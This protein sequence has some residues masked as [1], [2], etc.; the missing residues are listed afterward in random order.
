M[1]LEELLEVAI[2]LIFVWLVISMATMQAQEVIASLTKK[3]AKDLSEAIGTMIENEA[4]HNKIYDHPLIKNIKVPATGW[5][6]L[7]RRKIGINVPAFD[8]PP[9][10]PAGIFATVIFDV[11]TNAGTSV[12]PIK[13]KFSALRKEVGRLKAG[14]QETASALLGHIVDLGQALAGTQ[15][16]ATKIQIRTEINARL[17]QLG[18]I[19][20][21]GETPLAALTTD[22]AGVLNTGTGDITNLFSGVGT[23]LDQ[24][25]T[26]AMRTGSMALGDA[27]TSLLAGVEEYATDADKALAIGRKNVEA[28][29]DNSM[30]RLSSWYKRWAQTWAFFIGLIIALTLNI[31]SIELAKHLWREPAIRQVLAA[32]ATKFVAENPNLPKPGEDALPDVVKDLQEKFV[33]LN[34]PVGWIYETKP[35]IRDD[36]TGK[37]KMDLE[38]KLPV[39]PNPE[40]YMTYIK[41]ASQ[42]YKIM[43]SECI[44]YTN[45]PTTKGEWSLK[46]LGIFLTAI[47]TMQGAP[48]W[49]DIL[50]KLINV[51]NTGINPAEKSKTGSSDK[52]R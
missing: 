52:E 21:N 10:I 11:V 7:F 5:W 13:D 34:L 8:N 28:W 35:V 31:D 2:G 38:N 23:Y 24:I 30:D 37:I 1:Y 49:F 44:L 6:D 47:A 33:T 22:L 20:V 40:T 12:S 43:G 17:S 39:C 36:I 50:K 25:R 9:Y 4:I 29:F 41:D 27:L 18:S 42:P 15:I 32:N 16:E 26:G 3:R 45:L 19:S 48:I 51:R 46:L 14:D